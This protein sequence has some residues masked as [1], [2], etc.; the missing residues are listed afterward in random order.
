MKSNKFDFYLFL[1]FAFLL[2]GVY[3]GGFQPIRI[4]VLGLFIY[5]FPLIYRELRNYKIQFYFIIFMFLYGF[6]S[7]FFMI[8][9][10]QES[11]LNYFYLVINL[12]LY[13]VFLIFYKNANNSIDS[14]IKGGLFFTIFSLIYAVY[15]IS[16]GNHLSVNLTHDVESLIARN[17]S[18]FTFGNYNTFLMVLIMMMPFLIY[19]IT[20]KNIYN[21]IIS[22]IC[23]ITLSYVVITNASRSATLALAISYMFLLL[24]KGSSIFKILTVL[25]AGYFLFNNMEIFDVLLN[26]YNNVGYKSAG[27]WEVLTLPF[28]GL[29]EN[30]FLGFGIGN[31]GYYASNNLSQMEV[32][33]AHNFFGE[34]FYELGIITLTFI[35]IIIINNLKFL[36][37]KNLKTIILITHLIVVFIP[38]SMINSGYLV[39]VYVWLYLALIT[40][41]SYFEGS[42][43]VR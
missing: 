32:Y 42:K 1:I 26:R 9:N 38:F 3:G 39:G 29:K 5:Y 7:I 17:Y 33:A 16:T 30:L 36:L 35:I 27:R 12:M 6:F 11:L 4:F 24:Y 19:T 18:S 21:K 10:I 13:S 31:F 22:G 23:L 14:C 37:K 34:T 25:F 15:E 43:N 28:E 8:E 2:F 41:I 40:A 20:N